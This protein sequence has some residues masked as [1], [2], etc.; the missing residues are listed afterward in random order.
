[1]QMVLTGQISS[2]CGSRFVLRACLSSHFERHA[3]ASID[4]APSPP[5]YSKA[6]RSPMRRVGM[7]L[8]LAAG[9]SPAARG[10]RSSSG[11]F[12]GQHA[13]ARHS[14]DDAGGIDDDVGDEAD[15]KDSVNDGDDGFD[16]DGYIDV[17][18]AATDASGGDDDG[19]GDGGAAV[20]RLNKL[21]A[22]LG[23]C[24]RREADRYIE[25]GQ[26]SVAGR[27]VKLGG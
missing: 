11:R 27:T 26:V 21:M 3:F 22:Q 2:T 18:T 14:R 4:L 24:S 16:D 12:S 10:T 15:E 20:V 1:M 5:N 6:S 25:R 23:L 17:L 7:D 19:A 13:S 9:R 8:A